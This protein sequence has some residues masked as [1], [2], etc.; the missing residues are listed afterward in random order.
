LF[1]TNVQNIL[2]KKQKGKIN[3]VILLKLN[4]LGVIIAHYNPCRVVGSPRAL[5]RGVVP[6]KAAA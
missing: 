2:L 3:F 1:A 4:H 5:P 6:T